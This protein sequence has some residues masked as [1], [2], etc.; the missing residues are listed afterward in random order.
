MT[1]ITVQLDEKT[2]GRLRAEA[3]RQHVTIEQVVQDAVEA[4]VADDPEDTP[5]EEI[6]SSIEKGLREA[7]AGI[8]RPAEE[9]LAEIRQT[10]APSHAD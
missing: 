1:D 7:K 4:Y 9:V 2:L 6:L 10:F 8:G 3:E 5:D